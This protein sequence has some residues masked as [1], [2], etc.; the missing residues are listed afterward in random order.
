MAEN[1]LSMIDWKIKI[2]R[3]LL[4][5]YSY[6]YYMANIIIK[7]TTKAKNQTNQ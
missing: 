5:V 3:H 1:D 2:F 4:F 7:T 6:V